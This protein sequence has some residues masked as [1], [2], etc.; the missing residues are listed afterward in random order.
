MM[1]ELPQVVSWPCSGTHFLL[2]N[3][4]HN[5]QYEDASLA[6]DLGG[7]YQFYIDSIPFDVV[8]WGKIFWDHYI[9]NDPMDPDSGVREDFA[10]ASGGGLLFI[11]RNPIDTFKS[12][13]WK[14]HSDLSP[15]DAI[16]EQAIRAWR[17]QI[18]HCLDRH[19]FPVRY[20]DLRDKPIHE[21]NRLQIWFNLPMR[22]DHY[23][24]I[25]Q[26]VGKVGPKGRTPKGTLSETVL[27]RFDILPE[28]F[29]DYDVGRGKAA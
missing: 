1:V 25:R 27:Q 29:L 4:W 17:D 6:D 21:L 11:Y 22:F 16:T 28:R 12:W 20:E 26:F 18:L 15:E 3:L 19:V 9:F 24:V 10:R 13:W 14:F 5:F 23:R 2:A 7:P 8:P